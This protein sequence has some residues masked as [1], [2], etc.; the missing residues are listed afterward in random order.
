VLT[1]TRSKLEQLV[2]DLIE[3]TRQPVE[4]AIAD[5]G[6]A[7]SK[8]DEVVLV[9]GMTRMPLAYETV[10]KIFGKE[11]NKSVNPDEVV[12]V[13][14][15]VQ[16][17]VLSGEKTDILLLDVTPLSLGIE[18]LGG[19]N[20]ILIPRNTTIPTRKSEIF[21]TASDN[22]TSVEVHVL[23]GERPMAADNR[24]LGKFHLVGI[25]P[26][27]R[28]IPQIEVTFDIDANGI[29]NVSAK[30]MGTGRE[31]KI[32]I[33]ASSGLS[34]DEIDKMMREAES[35]SAE[36]ARRREEIE[37]RNRLD[38][39]VYQIEKTFSE[40]KE[41][42]DGATVSQIETAIADSKKALEEGG[43]E[44]MN[45]A[46]ENLQT[47]SHKLAEALYQGTGSASGATGGEQANAAGASGTTG[48]ASSSGGGGEDNVIDAEYVDVDENK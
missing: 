27:P 42:L 23:Q 3:K 4:R 32:T 7:P 10:K 46:F 29:V 41:K 45:N 9:G 21:S 13:G 31:Q 20:T 30:D 11:P 38:G 44:R 19:V 35:H 15:A 22:Q 1:L 28:G 47:A 48:G 33:T 39:L 12:A 37:A 26:A 18:T 5:A 43:V 36:D 25:P 24:T 17:G 16:A 8:I 6:V 40:N 14:A 2:G 34:K